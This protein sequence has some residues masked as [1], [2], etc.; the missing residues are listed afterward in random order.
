MQ[1]VA[2]IFRGETPTRPDES[3]VTDHRWGFIQRCWS[4]F[5]VVVQRPSGEE[6][7]AFSRDDLVGNS[8]QGKLEHTQDGMNTLI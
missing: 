8:P 4:P 5:R 3:S 7:V 1:I 2:A 6:I